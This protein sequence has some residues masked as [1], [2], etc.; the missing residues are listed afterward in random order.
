MRQEERVRAEVWQALRGFVMSEH[1]R[2]LGTLTRLDVSA[3]DL[4]ALLSLEPGQGQP[5]RALADTWHCDASTVTWIVDRL[6]KR[7]LVRRGPH[8]TDRRVK[9][10]VLSEEGERIRTRWLDEVHRP[11]AVLADLSDTELRALCALVDRLGTT[12]TG[13]S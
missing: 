5:M 6:E 13:G 10:V 11:P 3:G 1:E 8:Q 12:A 2:H 4:K 9:V 7:G